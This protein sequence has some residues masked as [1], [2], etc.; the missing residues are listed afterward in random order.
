M[1]TPLITIYDDVLPL[2]DR[3]D[4]FNKFF[5]TDSCY[6]VW[7]DKDNISRFKP[8]AKLVEIASS[9]FNFLQYSGIEIWTHNLTSPTFHYDNDIHLYTNTGQHSLPICT[10]IYYVEI[11]MPEVGLGNFKYSLQTPDVMIIPKDNRMVVMAPGILH[12]TDGTQSTRKLIAF[13]PWIN[14]PHS[15]KKEKHNEH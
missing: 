8:V 9:K 4:I 10:V 1:K 5:S 7:V 11:T 15:L 13:S 12:G 3:V 14:P 6:K 2:K